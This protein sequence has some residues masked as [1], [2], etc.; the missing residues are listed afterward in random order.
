[1]I[2]RE[3][4]RV[5]GISVHASGHYKSIHGTKLRRAFP[6]LKAGFV[7]P[8][9]KEA[10]LGDAE[11]LRQSLQMEKAAFYEDL[12]VDVDES[13]TEKEKIVGFYLSRNLKEPR[14]PGEVFFQLKKLVAANKGEYSE[15]EDRMILKVVEEH[16]ETPAAWRML[17]QS[18][19]RPYRSVQGRYKQDLLHKDKTTKGKLS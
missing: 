18:L 12:I 14:H 15:E 1:M 11:K 6:G 13:C 7:T 19:G 17:S 2:K 9:E 4:I 5:P 16:G 3:N 10:I 8:M